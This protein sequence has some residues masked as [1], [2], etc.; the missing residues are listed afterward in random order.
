LFGARELFTFF[1]M[2]LSPEVLVQE[3]RLFVVASGECLGLDAPSQ[4]LAGGTEVILKTYHIVQHKSNARVSLQEKSMPTAAEVAAVAADAARALAL[5]LP[6]AHFAAQTA[7]QPAAQ[8]A[9]E[10]A[11]QQ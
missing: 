11:A 6:A 2:P 3:D 4:Q 9:E 5:A 8:P 10:P 7:A 1:T